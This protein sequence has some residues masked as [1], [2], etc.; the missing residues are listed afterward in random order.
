MPGK[1]TPLS[2]ELITNTALDV[3]SREGLGALSMRR[4]AQELDVWPMSMYRHFRDKEELLD[5]VAAAGAEDVEL[6]AGRRGGHKQ[7]EALALEARALLER[8]PRD[9]RRRALTSPGALRLS[10]AAVQALTETGLP[11]AEAESAW[12]AVLAY[13]IG[14]IELDAVDGASEGAFEGGLERVLRGT[15]T[16]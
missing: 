4:L 7:V 11:P 6:P 5:A 16:V 1:R 8:Q 3:V 10:D 9:L 13:V 2:R 12:R 14:S 15:I